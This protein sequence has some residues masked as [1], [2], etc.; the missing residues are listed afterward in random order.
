M[1][2]K[3]FHVSNFGSFAGGLVADQEGYVT[4]HASDRYGKA[5]DAQIAELAATGRTL[6]IRNAAQA[7]INERE[8][9]KWRSK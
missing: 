7:E 4:Y 1:K 9:N 5:S 2:T 3:T 6:A 8:L